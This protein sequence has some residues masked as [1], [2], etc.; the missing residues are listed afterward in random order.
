MGKHHVYLISG[1]GADERV[2]ER[3]QFHALSVNYLPWLEPQ[4]QEN[5][6]HYASRMAASIKPE[7]HNVA[8]VGLSFGGIMAQEIAA[9]GHAKKLVLLSTVKSRAELPKLIKLG[10]YLPLQRIPVKTERRVKSIK[11]WGK[12]FGAI[13]PTAQIMFVDMMRQYTNNYLSW[14]MDQVSRWKGVQHQAEVLHLHG[15]NDFIFPHKLIRHASFIE[16]ATHIMVYSHAN[17]INPI[18]NQFLSI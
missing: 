4:K 2:F 17:K 6:A 18:I 13:H 5:I 15:T 10:T 16:G 11:F 1:L 12:Y 7:H 14:S 9:Q 8:I 3:L